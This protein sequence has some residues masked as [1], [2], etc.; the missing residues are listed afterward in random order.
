MGI[1]P[2]TISVLEKIGVSLAILAVGYILI[3][4]ITRIQK[5]V[6]ARSRIDKSLHTF[7]INVTRI[8][9]WVVLIIMVLQSL[10]VSTASLVAVLGA[11]GAAVA[12]ALR[13]SLANVAGGILII[14]NKPFRQGDEI[15]IRAASVTTGIVDHI[16]VMATRLHTWDNRV[17]SVPNG[18]ITTAVLVNYT[19]AGLRRVDRKFS[20]AYGNDIAKVK[21]ALARAIAEDPIFVSEPRPLIGLSE[22]G[23]N[24]L[25]FDC[26][27][28]CHTDDYYS[29]AYRMM[30]D[31]KREFD[32]QG[33]EVPFPQVDVHM[34]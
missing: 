10:G 23:A 13:D 25:I 4:I 27:A 7:L 33:I 5:K 16:D 15:E 19:E 31:V 24:A 22:H 1:S 2:G 6:L 21:A 34:K 8:L 29:A 9:L 26:K 3:H 28:W 18:V 30:E 32:S 12:L 11:G 20:A 14:L 17:V